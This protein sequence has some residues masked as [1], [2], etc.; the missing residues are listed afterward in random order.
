MFG[1]GVVLLSVWCAGVLA[2][3]STWEKPPAVIECEERAKDEPFYSENLTEQSCM[4][5]FL[6][7][8]LET[9]KTNDNDNITFKQFEQMMFGKQL[10]PSGPRVRRDIRVLNETELHKL[11]DAFDVLYRNG[12]MASFGRLHGTNTHLKHHGASFLP[13]HRV[14]IAAF[15]E[16]LR[17][18]DPDVSLPYWDYSMDY[19]MPK[20]SMSIVWSKCFFGNG[21]GTVLK[22]PFQSIYGGFNTP[23]SRDIAASECH[24]LISKEDIDELMT[25]C[26]FADITI[27]KTLYKNAS[28][29][30]EKL[31]D[32]VHDWV[33]GDMGYLGSAAYDPI[34]YMHHAFID[35]I[36]EKFRS[37]QADECNVD[38][39]KDYR[40][41]G[42]YSVDPNGQ[43]GPNDTMHGFEYLKN[44]DGL[45]KNWTTAFYSYEDAP[46]C[47]KC[48]NSK[49]LYCNKSINPNRPNG[50]CVPKTLDLCVNPKNWTYVRDALYNQTQ[51]HGA[52]LLMGP[53]RLQ[54][55]GRTRFN[56]EQEGLVLLKQEIAKGKFGDFQFFILNFVQGMSGLLTE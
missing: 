35:Y 9:N 33:G 16:K 50:V 34:F 48:G 1:K 29:N 42:D 52:K 20:P 8:L 43:Q 7:D 22:G 53:A 24:G 21:V 23:V 25:F 30:L 6:V 19:Y 27:G 17:E 3:K 11:F 31:H 5:T 14:F 36:W 49:Y 13:W 40:E 55:Y 44:I 51:N 18:V 54:G 37:R 47:P 2:V 38:I 41:P 26:N 45:W 28:H 32:D 46:E 56:T 4:R 39:E 15:E 12:T 10:P